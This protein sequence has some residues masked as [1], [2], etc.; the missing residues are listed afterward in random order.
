MVSVMPFDFPNQTDLREL[1]KTIYIC[2]NGILL[3]GISSKQ[4]F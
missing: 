3:E 4:G 1:N 2:I